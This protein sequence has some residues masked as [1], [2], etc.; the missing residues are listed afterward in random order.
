MPI[1]TPSA[2]RSSPPPHLHDIKIVETI[3]QHG[4]P[5]KFLAE[6]VAKVVRRIGGNYK[7]LVPGL[8]KLNG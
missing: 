1:E 6:S 2:C 8:C 5:P 3:N 4:V 7:N